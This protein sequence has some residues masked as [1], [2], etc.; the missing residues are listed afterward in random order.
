M[1]NHLETNV[2]CVVFEFDTNC[3]RCEEKGKPA[4]YT[5]MNI[6]E[7]GTP[8]CEHCGQDWEIKGTCVIKA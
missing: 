7:S 3:K 5:I 8:G 2:E 6:L 4:F 1:D